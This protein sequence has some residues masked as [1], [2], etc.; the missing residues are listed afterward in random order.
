MFVSAD[1]APSSSFMYTRYVYARSLWWFHEI[2]RLT[3]RKLLR[4][5]DSAMR[6]V[7]LLLA[8]AV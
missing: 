8:M 7:A 6:N 1:V 3:G 4:T 5:A 2:A